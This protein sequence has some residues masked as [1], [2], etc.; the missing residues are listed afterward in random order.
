[1]SLA[2]RQPV[3]LV[4]R[5]WF[6]RGLEMIRHR[7]L[8]LA[9]LWMDWFRK[10]RT[11]HDLRGWYSKTADFLEQS[12][13]RSSI[14]RYS[15]RVGSIAADA[16]ESLSSF[17]CSP[18]WRSFLEGWIILYLVF[19][20]V[21][22]VWYGLLPLLLLYC[23]VAVPEKR[24]NASSLFLFGLLLFAGTI[25]TAAGFR[26]S[27]QRLLQLESWL[28]LAW[29]TGLAFTP[30]LLG[31]VMRWMAGSSPLWM[32]MGFQQYASGVRTAAGWLSPDQAALI[33]V[34]V[35]SVFGNPNLYAL[36]LLLTL[37]FCF[38]LVRAERQRLPRLFWLAVG[39]MAAVSLYLTYSRGAWLIGGI[40]LVLMSRKELRGGWLPVWGLLLLILLTFPAFRARLGSLLTLMDSSLHFRWRIWEGVVRAIP[41][42]WLWGAG[43]GSFGVVYPWFMLPNSAA[44]HA[45]QWYL[46]IWLEHGIVVLLGLGWLLWERLR[47]FRR[48]SEL[49]RTAALVL[50]VF[51]LYG[52][53]ESW[54]VHP[55]WGGYFWF[56]MGLTFACPQKTPPA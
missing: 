30:R 48:F 38:G 14:R 23:G 34:R 28:L 5:S 22:G 32:M 42:T 47:N 1:M 9:D 31:K 27:W 2:V 25:L 29:F 12:W 52:C 16:R 6:G 20:P 33:P 13:H 39:G 11:Y 55:L 53:M 51:L 15:R 49:L 3:A 7:V 21:L 24:V 36:Y 46:Q 43:P 50:I 56:L 26:Q 35:Y 44:E 8:Q 45:H 19:L 18:W 10:S 40:I 4:R 41:D 17:R 37:V 54:D